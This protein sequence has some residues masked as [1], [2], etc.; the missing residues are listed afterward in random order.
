MPNRAVLRVI[1]FLVVITML[2]ELSMLSERAPGHVPAAW[3]ASGLAVGLLLT[4]REPAVRHL[5]M[6]FLFATTV[7]VLGTHETPGLLAVAFGLSFVA[8]IWTSRFVLVFRRTGNATLHDTRDLARFLLAAA[9][10]PLVGVVV[11]EG[12]TLATGHSV[13]GSGALALF[14]THLAAQLILLPVFLDVGRGGVARRPERL[15]QWITMLAVATYVMTADSRPPL[16]FTIAPVLAWVAYRSSVREAATQMVAVASIAAAITFDGHGP[17][18]QVVHEYGLLGGSLTTMLHFFLIDCALVSLPLSVAA[19]QQRQ[20]SR[21]AAAERATLERVVSAARGTAIIAS[22]ENGRITLFNPGAETMLGWAAEDVIGGFPDRFFSDAEVVRHA[23]ALGVRP[24]FREVAVTIASSDEPRRTWHYVRGDGEERVMLMTLSL[25]ADEHGGTTGYLATGEDVTDRENTQQALLTAL[26][27]ER[28][29]VER[30]RELDQAKSD[31]VSTVSHELR[32]PI[33][34]I[35]GYTELLEDGVTGQLTPG[36]L[37]LVGRVDR[38]S[39]RLLMLIEDLLTLATIEST[40]LDLQ[41]ARTDLRLALT[42]AYDEVVSSSSN[43]QLE[44]VLDLPHDPVIHHG[45]AVQ[46]ER[47]ARN[48]LSNAVK[49]TPDGGTIEVRLRPRGDESQLVFRDN[50]MGIPEDEQPLLFRRFFRSRIATREAIQGTGLGLSIVHQI[51]TQHGGSIAVDSAP[52]RGTTFTV[53][54]PRDGLSAASGPGRDI[55][56]DSV[57]HVRSES[58]TGA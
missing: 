46:L 11:F 30:L 13:E 34:S 47:M 54:L 35:V 21:D 1:L 52:D 9:G 15:L 3:P 55:A 31:F 7:L 41:P 58:A 5:A 24:S 38:N 53:L 2:E 20:A 4:V 50:G 14:T 18:T 57:P 45:D 10:S 32:T 22:D 28:D 23:E 56:V 26:E 43:R 44:I 33:T 49:F 16:L 6:G 19:T 39:R 8:E 37:D 51:I 25:I 36:Q 12:L 48:I 40:G 42:S 17:I 27:H 29:A